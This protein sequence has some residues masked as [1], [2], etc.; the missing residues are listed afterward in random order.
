[1]KQPVV[2]AGNPKAQLDQ[3]RAAGVQGFIHIGTDAVT[4]LTQWQKRLGMG[5]GEK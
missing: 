1:M 2:V 3:L 4:A 5:E